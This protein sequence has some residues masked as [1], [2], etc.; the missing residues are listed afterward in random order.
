M[1]IYIITLFSFLSLCAV[2]AQNLQELEEDQNPNYKIA[3]DKYKE[4]SKELTLLEGTTVQETYKAIDPLE[5]KREL[6]S[7]RRK[8]RAQRPYWRHQ[9]RM[10]RIKNTRYFENNGFFNYGYHNN[11]FIRRNRR[12]MNHNYLGFGNSVLGLGLLSSCLF[13]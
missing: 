9:R 5:E 3:M 11:N 8:F 12:F 6:K 4:H 2:S 13:N 7:Q 1:K 10:E